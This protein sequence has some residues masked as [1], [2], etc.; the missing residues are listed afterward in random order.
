MSWRRQRKSSPRSCSTRSVALFTLPASR[1]Q[2]LGF[3]PALQ[4]KGNEANWLPC[5]NTAA[6]YSLFYLFILCLKVHWHSAGQKHWCC[7]LQPK[8]I[9]ATYWAAAACGVVLSTSDMLIHLVPHTVPGGRCKLF[10]LCGEEAEALR[11]SA[12]CPRPHGCWASGS[13]PENRPA[14]S[15]AEMQPSL[16]TVTWSQWLLPYLS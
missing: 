11:G 9:L 7:L 3:I 13:V 8:L 10:S 6:F 2:A 16:L 14:G 1:P 4:G 15:R 12:L 5:A